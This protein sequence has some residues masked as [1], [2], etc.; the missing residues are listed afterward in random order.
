MAEYFDRI[1]HRYD[2][3]YETGTGRYVDRT[4][5]WLIFSMLRSEGGRALDLGCGTGNYTAELHRRGFYVVGLDASERMLEMARKK[6]PSSISG[7]KL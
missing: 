4:E 6:L 2:R 1:S 7:R 3:W 5:K